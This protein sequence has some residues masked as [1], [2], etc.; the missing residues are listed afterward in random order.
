M[1]LVAIEALANLSSVVSNQTENE[2]IQH[3]SSDPNSLQPC[4]RRL[5]E[6]LLTMEKRWQR[7][8]H[9]AGSYFE[10]FSFTVQKCLKKFEFLDQS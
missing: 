10:E 5:S 6:S 8:V 7:C 4:L 1:S 3:N 2:E 9:A